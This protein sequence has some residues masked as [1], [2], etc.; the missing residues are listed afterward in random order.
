MKRAIRI[1]GDVAYVPLTKGYEAVIDAADVSLVDGF[2]WYANVQP[3]AVYAART[4]RSS[5]K[6][7]TVTLHRLLADDPVGM[8]VD[9]RDADGLNNRR[10][11]LRVATTAQN[12]HNARI[13]KRNT[14]GLKGVTF[15]KDRGK[16]QAK[17]MRDRKRHHIGYFGCPTTAH[18]AYVKASRLLHGEFGRIA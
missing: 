13:S 4:D 14:S 18:F 7:R 8:E 3:R 5:H 9:H 16:W 11:N 6:P 1:E 15:N 2:S 10:D 17:I 12:Q